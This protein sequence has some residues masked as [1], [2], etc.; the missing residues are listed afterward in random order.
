MRS[1]SQLSLPL[2]RA[3]RR[4]STGHR[5]SVGSPCTIHSASALPAPPADAMPIE[6]K[7]APTQTFS[8]PGAGPRMKL[9]SAVND[10][11]PL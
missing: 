5:S 10:S 9:L 6:L 1:G 7:P 3:K 8:S 4:M 11:G 2:K